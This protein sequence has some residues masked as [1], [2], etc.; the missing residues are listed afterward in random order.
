MGINHI[1]KYLKSIL[2]G[3]LK[4]TEDSEDSCFN[5]WPITYEAMVVRK[6]LFSQCLRFP[7]INANG[8]VL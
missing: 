7:P 2:L 3:S 4:K 5:T 1:V 8:I 6:S